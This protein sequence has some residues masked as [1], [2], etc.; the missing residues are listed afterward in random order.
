M[1]TAEDENLVWERVETVLRPAFNWYDDV[2]GILAP[3]PSRTYTITTHYSPEGQAFFAELLR[4]TFCRMVPS[5]QRILVLDWQHPCYSVG[6]HLLVT[7]THWPIPV[8][9]DGDHYFFLD[10]SFRW[11]TYGHPGQQSL[12]IFGPLLPQVENELRDFPVLWES[13]K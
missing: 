2:P 9:P 5:G 3:A 10:D 13:T 1:L 6:P 12:C 8:L 4:P 7:D 11:G